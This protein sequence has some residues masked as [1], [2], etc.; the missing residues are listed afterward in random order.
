MPSGALT[1]HRR[2]QQP[3]PSEPPLSPLP[4]AFAPHQTTPPNCRAAHRTRT[5]PSASWPS[6]RLGLDLFD[7]GRTARCGAT[8][9]CPCGSTRCRRATREQRAPAQSGGHHLTAGGRSL[10]LVF[11]PWLSCN[12]CPVPSILRRSSE[13]SAQ[14]PVNHQHSVECVVPGEYDRRRFK[15]LR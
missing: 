9:W 13:S 8:R 3:S 10:S 4:P 7:P 14:C 5:G 6:S 2:T 1:P 11:S 15:R 12:E